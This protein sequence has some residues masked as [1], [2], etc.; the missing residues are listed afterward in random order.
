MALFLF[1]KAILEN[2]PI[3]VF[4]HGRMKRDFTYIDDIVEGVVRV[5]D[6]TAEPD[7]DWSGDAPDSATSY[8][9]YRLY[10]IGHNNAVELLEFSG[11]LEGAN[12]K[13]A[14]KNMLPMQAGDVPATYA[15]VESLSNEIGFRPNTSIETGIG[16]FVAW[17][18]E[19]YRIA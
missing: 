4:N 14:V 10:N 3:D 12:G 16:N 15:D 6:R 17:Y 7:P 18:K 11:V 5:L 8:A 1:T 2:R 9:P 13:R 19:Y